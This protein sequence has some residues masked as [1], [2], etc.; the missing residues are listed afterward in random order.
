MT[1]RHIWPGPA[2]YLCTCSKVKPL[3]L[4]HPR[5]VRDYSRCFTVHRPKRLSALKPMNSQS[6]LQTNILFPLIST[7][8]PKFLTP[9]QWP[10]YKFNCRCQCCRKDGQQRRTSKQLAH[11]HQQ[12]SAPS[13]LLDLIFS[14]THEEY[15]TPR[16][17]LPSAS[18]TKADQSYRSAI[19]APSP[20]MSASKLKRQSRKSKT[21][22]PARLASR[23][24]H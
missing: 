11:C 7:E 15:A 13:N 20:K 8:I 24:T 22:M 23:R 5:Q 16:I 2:L 19:S 18:D 12:R 3:S 14:L 17:Q 9:V 6:R 21:T 4:L 1:I 10:Q